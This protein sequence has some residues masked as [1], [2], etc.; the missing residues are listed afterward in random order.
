MQRIRYKKTHKLGYLTELDQSE[1]Q[2]LGYRWQLKIL[3]CVIS[4]D[5]KIIW[6][7]NHNDMNRQGCAKIAAELQLHRVSADSWE[8]GLAV[9]DQE[10][11]GEDLACK[12][13]KFLIRHG[14]KLRAGS[15]QSPGGRY[16][17]YRLSQSQD[18]Q[19]LAR[20][21]WGKKVFK[22]RPNHAQKEAFHPEFEY[23]D[24]ENETI[25]TALVA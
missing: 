17:W 14:T 10:F 24:T 18:I 4:S 21:K 7:V 3:E 1:S 20:K 23:L 25:V 13:Y 8:V 22:L 19:V 6:V 2:T 11:R 16:I 9:V 15:A 5:E 12:I